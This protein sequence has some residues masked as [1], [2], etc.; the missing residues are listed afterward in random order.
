M[1]V[2]G[3]IPAS[4]PWGVGST[5]FVGRSVEVERLDA[6]WAA[7]LDDRRQA[8]FIGGEPGV[9]KTRLVAEMAA[10]LRAQG[11]SVPGVHAGPI[12]TSRTGRSSPS[13]RRS[14]ITQHRMRCGRYPRSSPLR[15]CA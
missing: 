7:A 5:A 2:L 1:S 15:W 6:A 13:S 4:A 10:A 11:A 9:G 12:S 3:S 8:I 14:S